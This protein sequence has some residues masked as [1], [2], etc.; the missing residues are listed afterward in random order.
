MRL[1]Q[2][3]TTVGGRRPPR[4]PLTLMVD[5]RYSIAPPIDAERVIAAQLADHRVRLDDH[6]RPTRDRAVCCLTG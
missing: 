3:T 5:A 2:P 4:H 6:V 1:G